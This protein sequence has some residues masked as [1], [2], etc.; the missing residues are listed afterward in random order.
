MES[1]PQNPELPGP[2][3]QSVASLTTDPGVQSVA[4]PTTDPGVASLILD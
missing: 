4:S 2:V 3:G 1:Q